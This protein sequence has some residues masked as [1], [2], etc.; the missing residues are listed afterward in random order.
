MAPPH[1]MT[2]HP[3]IGRLLRR[4]LFVSKTFRLRSLASQTTQQIIQHQRH[5]AAKIRA[6][7]RAAT[8]GL[9]PPLSSSKEP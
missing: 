9:P 6:Q 7:R 1:A 2:P 4:A 3:E 5:C 8:A